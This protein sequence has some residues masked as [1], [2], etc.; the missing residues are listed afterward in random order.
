MVAE[1]QV[2]HADGS[3][4]FLQSVVTNLIHEPSVGGLVLNSRDVT[5]QKT[6][7]DQLR[8]QASTT[9]TGLANRACS[10]STS[11]RLSGARAGWA[12]NSPFSLST[13]TSSKQSMTCTAT[14][15]VTSC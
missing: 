9:I 5:A 14:H 8:H 11:I 7:E 10:Q 3:W 4:R 6:L 2:R 13:W 1:W 15:W 12:A